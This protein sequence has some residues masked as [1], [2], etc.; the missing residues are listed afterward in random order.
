MAL[1]ESIGH[2]Q[3]L[4]RL[5]DEQM[6]QLA[7]EIREFLVQEIAKTGGHL[8]PNLGVVETTIAI[9]RVFDSP[10]DAG[11]RVGV[12]KRGVFDD[13]DASVRIGHGVAPEDVHAALAALL[14]AEA[15]K[16]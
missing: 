15:D 9:H 3:D 16:P 5:T 7:A 6:V 4:S 8:G 2:P 12:L 11:A 14:A 13:T 10:K 1:L